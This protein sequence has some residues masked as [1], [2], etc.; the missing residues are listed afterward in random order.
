M[1]SFKFKSI[2]WLSVKSRYPAC[3]S[4]SLNPY[5][6]ISQTWKSGI[7]KKGN[8]RKANPLF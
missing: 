4:I 5:Y 2:E 1:F 8:I 3:C 6:G 7:M